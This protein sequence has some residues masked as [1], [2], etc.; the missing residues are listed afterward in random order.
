M[1]FSHLLVFFPTSSYTLCV[2]GI[3]WSY[4]GCA[5]G[6]LTIKFNSIKFDSLGL[7]TK[8]QKKK[9]FV[10]FPSSEIS[11]KLSR[12]VGN[13]LSFIFLKHPKYKIWVTFPPFFSKNT[14]S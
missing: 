10:V 5:R 4:N 11:E 14:Q 8:G 6:P 2:F 9:K 3:W 1:L 7:L 12:S 13:Y